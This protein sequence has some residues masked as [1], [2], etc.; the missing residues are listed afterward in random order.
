VAC[1]WVAA[2]VR[3]DATEYLVATLNMTP[4]NNEP[5]DDGDRLRDLAHLSAAVGHHVINAFSA[6]V[7]NAELIR[8]PSTM[9]TDPAEL[10]TLGTAIVDT[11]IDASHVARGLINWARRV[12]AVDAEF[13]G[14]PPETVDLNA[15]LKGVLESE[16]SRPDRRVDLTDELAP[17]PAISG[18]PPQLRAMVLNLIQNAREAMVDGTGTVGFTT[19]TDDRGWVVMTIRDS[20]CGMS[21][22]VLRRATE[23]FFTTKP[24]HGGIGLT[25][26]QGIWRRHH[27]SMAIESSP[28]QGT[29]IRLSIGPIS[30]ASSRAQESRRNA[31]RPGA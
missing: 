21:P 25:V 2:T 9:R 13:R 3:I 14:C 26:A 23:P 18:D 19:Q 1:C 10:A 22:E 28:G 7:S 4:G 20:G 15:L 31:V 30:P 29:T 8:A 12:T 24:G 27:G 6:A 11:A 17:I 5:A 16:K